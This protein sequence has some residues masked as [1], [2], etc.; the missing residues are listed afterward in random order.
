MTEE[1]S[2]LDNETTTYEIVDYLMNIL[3]ASF[4][5]YVTHPLGF[6][7]KDIGFSFNVK[8]MEWVSDEKARIAEEYLLE[9]GFEKKEYATGTQYIFK[10][11][12]EGL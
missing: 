6:Y 5:G 1:T 4:D 2:L 8:I 11:E 3:G 10:R 7:A 9:K 12:K